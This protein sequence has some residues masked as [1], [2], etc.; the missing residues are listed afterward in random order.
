MPLRLGLLAVLV[1]LAASACGVR[2]YRLWGAPG[3]WHRTFGS[4]VEFE[5]D[6]VLCLGERRQARAA[7][8]RGEGSDAA[9]RRFSSC[10]DARGWHSR[11]AL[12]TTEIRPSELPSD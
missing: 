7:A 6:A 3:T 11:F 12:V 8:P 2:G 9:Y 4:R 5:R 10:M 1:L